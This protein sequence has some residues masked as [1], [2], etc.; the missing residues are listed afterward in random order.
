MRRT[1]DNDDA[2]PV[3]GASKKPYAAPRLVRYGDVAH[4]TRTA[5]PPGKLK[6][7]PNVNK[8]RTV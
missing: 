6:D 2:R 4:L 3:A 7:N 5:G 8:T 1:T